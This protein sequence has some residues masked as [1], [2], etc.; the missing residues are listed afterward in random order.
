MTD[1]IQRPAAMPRRGWL[2]IYI[3]AAPG[4]GKTY[5]MLQDADDWRR[6]GLDVVVGLIETHGRRDTAKQIGDLE[7]LPLAT[8]CYQGR[9]Y[10]ELDVEGIIRR[11]PKVVLIDELAHTNVPGS[12]RGKRFED[13]EFV[14]DHGIDVV[15]AVNIQHLESLQDKVEHITGVKVRE[16]VPDSFI[17]RARQVKL[18]DVAPETLQQR[19]EEGKIYALDKVEHAL[20]NFFQLGNL[21][22]LRE[23]AL[24]EV[25]DDVEQRLDKELSRRNRVTVEP[26]RILVC[27]NYRP[28]SEKLIRRGWR[29][30][31]RLNAK[32]YVLVVVADDMTGEEEKDLARIEALSR[33]FEAIF[34]KKRVGSRRVGEIIVEVAEEVHV[35]QIVIGQPLPRKNGMWSRFEENPVD[36]VLDHAEF[37]DL[38]VVANSRD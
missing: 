10:Q 37:M 21:A 16:R 34:I 7:T 33:Q 22:A 9:T 12:V 17:D 29:I 4:V 13:I 14:L 20:N 2:T 27:V 6:K 30:A 3:G 5:K 1:G 28:H 31:D 19:L 15:T 36:Y 24:L 18:I 25:A 23:I 8:I 11:H 35:S 38:H 32:L 26:E